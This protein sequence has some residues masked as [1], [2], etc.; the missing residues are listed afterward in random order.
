MRVSHEGGSSIFNTKTWY[1]NYLL[2]GEMRAFLKEEK[3]IG[4]LRPELSP[5][6]YS[7][8]MKHVTDGKKAHGLAN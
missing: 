7:L 3:Y 2:S 5:E 6:D 1:R 4:E 8:A